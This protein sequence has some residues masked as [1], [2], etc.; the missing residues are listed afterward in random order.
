MQFT[1]GFP[2]FFPPLEKTREFLPKTKTGD[3]NQIQWWR[4]DRP[5]APGT[6]RRA[7]QA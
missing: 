3:S 2:F 4:P 5:A 7:L 6:C 1:S